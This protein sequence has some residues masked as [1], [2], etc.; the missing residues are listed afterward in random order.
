ME[1]A[2][3][4]TTRWRIRAARFRAYKAYRNWVRPI[5]TG[6][7]GLS[8]YKTRISLLIDALLSRHEQKLFEKSSSASNV[9]LRVKALRRR[10][11]A[12]GTDDQADEETCRRPIFPI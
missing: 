2:F 10:L 9:P 1:R 6:K 7:G 4:S 8:S 12:M 11:L 5:R 3:Y